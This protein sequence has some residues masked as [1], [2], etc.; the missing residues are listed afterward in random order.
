[1]VWVISI[2]DVTSQ[3]ISRQD[4]WKFQRAIHHKMRTP[5]IGMYSGI[6]FLA[7]YADDMPI[8]DVKTLLNTALD[9]GERLRKSVEDVL[10]YVDAPNL[11]QGYK[12]FVPNQ[13]KKLV[14]DIKVSLKLDDVSIELDE[15]ATD[16]SCAVTTESMELILRELLEN[17]QKFHPEKTPHVVVHLTADPDNKEIVL[18]VSD[19]GGSIS[20][21][22]IKRVWSPYYQVEK[23]FTGEIEGMGLGLSTVASV[24][25]SVGG[26]CHMRNKE[27]EQGVEVI[28]HIPAYL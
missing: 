25:W 17:A 2:R 6:Q 14:H 26:Q 10:R 1:M 16:I 24:I 13:L 12:H 11:A 20:P 4:M 15:K 7:S 18:M 8:A 28:L 27:S 5:L 19:N 21:E 22:Q 3:I 23:N 9:H